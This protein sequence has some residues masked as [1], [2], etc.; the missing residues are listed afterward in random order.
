[1]KTV[2][3]APLDWGLGHASRSL[4]L[5]RRLEAEGWRVVL[6]GSGHSGR[7]M[8]EQRP[9]LPYIGFPSFTL[10]YSATRRQVGAVLLA[11]PRLLYRSFAEHFQVRR[12]V[13]EHAIDLVVSDNRFG[14]F[15]GGCRSVYLTHQIHI[16]LPRPYKWLEPVVDWLHRC[17]IQ[18]YDACWIPDIADVRHCLSGKL[19]HPGQL[20]SNASYIGPLSRFHR[21]MPVS[22]GGTLWLLSGIEPQRTLLEKALVASYSEGDCPITLVRGTDSVEVPYHL[23][24]GIQVYDSPDLATLQGLIACADRIV[25][26]SGYSTIMD[27][28]A[29]GKLDVVQ[30]VPT[31]GQPEQEY[32]TRWLSEHPVQ[33]LEA[34]EGTHEG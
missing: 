3:I 31:P 25:A 8:Q 13:R 7:W 15:G 28:A 20:P 18:R 17:L 4:A 6:A 22:G 29:M 16:E 12:L 24:K 34:G 32:L 2:L 21:Q 11:L 14:L 1:M 27:L 23:P 9:D 30:W 26:R 33:D 5:V 10:R 19:G